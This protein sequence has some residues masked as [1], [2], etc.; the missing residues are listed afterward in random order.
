MGNEPQLV[1]DRR[2]TGSA[3]PGVSPSSG[4]VSA[5][6][7]QGAAATC[8]TG[9]TR[10]VD[11]APTREF[12]L[13]RHAV[14]QNRDRWAGSRLPRA[15]YWR[16]PGRSF[17]CATHNCAHP[18]GSCQAAMC[19]RKLWGCRSGGEQHEDIA[20]VTQVFHCAELSQALG[21]ARQSPVSGTAAGRWRGGGAAGEEAGGEFDVAALLRGGVLDELAGHLG[22][23]A[24]E[25]LG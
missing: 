16:S 1:G 5:G 9:D 8:S 14:D 22:G 18:S 13:L 6:A 12:R 10:Q 7:A 17:R 23:G 2:E 4:T 11:M 24:A 25:V 21:A 19:R 20:T 15:G 3:G